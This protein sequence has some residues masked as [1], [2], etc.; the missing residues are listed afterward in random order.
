ARAHDFRPCGYAMSIFSRLFPKDEV[1][2]DKDGP[3]V[4]PEHEI[5]GPSDTTPNIIVPEPPPSRGASGGTKLYRTPAPATKT[6][7]PGKPPARAPLP[8]PGS[9]NEPTIQDALD[10]IFPGEGTASR[11]VHGTSTASDEAA[12]QAMFEDLAVAHMRPVRNMMLELR[13]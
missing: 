2:A 12:A 5:D 11:P 10:K 6:P 13:W 4:Q 7:P 9:A 1:G 8:P 3:G